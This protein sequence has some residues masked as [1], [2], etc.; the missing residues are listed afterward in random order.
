MM[1]RLLGV[2]LALALTSCYEPRD[3]DDVASMYLTLELSM[4]RHDPA[5]VDAYFGPDV[6]M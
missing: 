2:I 4:A 6:I 1:T 3:V 5:H